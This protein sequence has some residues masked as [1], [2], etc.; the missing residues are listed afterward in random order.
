MLQR[1]V[2]RVILTFFFLLFRV[3]V[4]ALKRARRRG[5]VRYA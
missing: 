1:A 4:I 2:D 5:K 3:A